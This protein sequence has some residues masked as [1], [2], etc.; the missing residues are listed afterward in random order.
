M[1][2]LYD[3]ELDCLAVSTRAVSEAPWNLQ[4]R[5]HGRVTEKAI[6]SMMRSLI[7]Q[8]F[9]MNERIMW[10]KSEREATE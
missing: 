8:G 10:F 9:G 1:S 2:Q 7:A 6:V 3:I 4:V 5:V